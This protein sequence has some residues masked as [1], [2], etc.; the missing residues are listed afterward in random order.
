MTA[1]VVT[2]RRV[3][4]GDVVVLVVVLV[5]VVL[6]VVVGL[7]V[8]DVVGG[9]VGGKKVTRSELGFGGLGGRVGLLFDVAH[10]HFVC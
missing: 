9:D 3:V 4:V 8:V 6:V 1:C 2:G 10:C 7:V 5:V